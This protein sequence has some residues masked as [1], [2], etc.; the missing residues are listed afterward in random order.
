MCQ[1][2]Q[3][4][5]VHDFGE[6]QRSLKRSFHSKFRRKSKYPVKQQG[7]GVEAPPPYLLMN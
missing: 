5:F 7:D 6:I 4:E 2:T 3:C 1:T